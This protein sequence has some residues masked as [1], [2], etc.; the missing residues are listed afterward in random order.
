M[1]LVLNHEETTSELAKAV[2]HIG[3]ALPRLKLQLDMFHTDSI[4]EAVERLYAD[5]LAFLLRS[6]Q[7]YEQSS[8][9]RIWGAIAKPYKLHFKDLRDRID[10]SARQV[11]NMAHTLTQEKINRILALLARVDSNINGT[12]VLV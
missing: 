9:K 11:D 1:Q 8:L 12:Y 5:I 3:G 7:W 4:R 10:E 2:S 6:L